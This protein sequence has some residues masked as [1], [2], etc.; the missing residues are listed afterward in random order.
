MKKIVIFGGSNGLGAAIVKQMLSLS[1]KAVAIVVDACPLSY[2]NPRVRYVQ[3]D[4]SKK[5]RIEDFF[6][7]EADAVVYTAG[8]GRIDRFEDFG[9]PETDKYFRVNT[10]TPIELL[11]RCGAA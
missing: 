6:F 5:Y 8:L 4:F 10:T 1:P 3:A 9:K 11:R 7:T 2:E